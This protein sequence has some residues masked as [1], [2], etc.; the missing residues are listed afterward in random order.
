MIFK[1]IN[2]CSN[3]LFLVEIYLNGLVCFLFFQGDHENLSTKLKNLS[4]DLKA[5]EK[6]AREAERDLQT[7][8][9]ELDRLQSDFVKV[10]LNT[11]RKD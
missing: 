4:T 1:I 6:I 7:K 11:K 5:K 10:L 3:L 2:V 8:K 9:E